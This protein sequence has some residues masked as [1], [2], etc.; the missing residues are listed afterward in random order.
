[1]HRQRPAPL[2][3]VAVRARAGSG[4]MAFQELDVDDPNLYTDL[5]EAG[6]I[7][8]GRAAQLLEGMSQPELRELMEHYTMPCTQC[9]STWDT[10]VHIV[11]VRAVR[12]GG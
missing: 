6:G 1:M 11:Q 3:C 12:V 5:E 10:L 9:A 7:V 2:E 8:A 4:Y